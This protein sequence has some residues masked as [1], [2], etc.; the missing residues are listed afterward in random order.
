[1]GFSKADCYSTVSNTDNDTDKVKNI[2]T[3]VWVSS[4]PLLTTV[5][6]KYNTNIIIMRQ[7]TR[8]MINKNLKQFKQLTLD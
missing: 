1:M 2:Y 5:G 7:Y 3:L 4:N 8:V 6:V